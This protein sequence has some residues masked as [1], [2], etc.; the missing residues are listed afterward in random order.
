MEVFITRVFCKSR[1]LGE[2]EEEEE[3]NIQ[4]INE[5]EYNS[6][7]NENR[8]KDTLRLAMT[9]GQSSRLR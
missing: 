6:L 2:E 3:S 8:S 7:I 1:K 5:N 9:R 4:M